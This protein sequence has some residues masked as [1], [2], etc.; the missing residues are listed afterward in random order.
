[1]GRK[2]SKP[3]VAVGGIV[4]EPLAR[5]LH[6]YRGIEIVRP[7]RDIQGHLDV[8]QEGKA[9]VVNVGG[10][11]LAM[12]PPWRKEWLDAHGLEVRYRHGRAELERKK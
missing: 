8:R 12:P 10:P 1:M 2:R 6:E 7:M 4:S 11:I 3:K 5:V 9:I